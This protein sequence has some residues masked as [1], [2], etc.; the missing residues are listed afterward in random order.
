M[1]AIEESEAEEARQTKSSTL[2]PSI[3]GVV[4]QCVGNNGGD[5]ACD[6]STGFER[7]IVPPLAVTSFSLP[8]SSTEANRD[9]KK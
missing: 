5:E 8:L 3:T 7:G 6:L 1:V 9:L 4:G 2:V